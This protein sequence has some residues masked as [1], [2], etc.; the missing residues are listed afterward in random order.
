M[1]IRHGDP[2]AAGFASFGQGSTLEWPWVK[3]EQTGCV[4]IGDHVEIRSHLCIEAQGVPPTVICRIGSGTIISH[5]VRFVALNGIEI[6]PECG[7][8]HGVTIA[9]CLHDYASAEADEPPWRTPLVAHGNPLRV[10]SGAWIGNNSLIIGGVTVGKRAIIAP[11]SVVT[12]D[13]PADTMVSGNPSRRV[14]F[15]PRR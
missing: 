2:L 15:E 12:R 3:L 6:E 1:T 7:I 4:A 8:G 11:H 10:E 9:D 5:N 13:V 14:P